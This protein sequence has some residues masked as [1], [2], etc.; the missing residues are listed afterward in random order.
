MEADGV[1][2]LSEKIG[3]LQSCARNASI[4]VRGYFDQ[5]LSQDI[6]LKAIRAWASFDPKKGSLK[7]WVFTIASRLTIDAR[8]RTSKRVRVE[9]DEPDQTSTHKASQRSYGA[10]NGAVDVHQVLC[11]SVG[12]FTL[13]QVKVL[14][15]G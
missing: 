15:Y 6:L 9:S 5:D 1:A 14:A 10:F 7:N 2:D 12:K 4:H 11:F 8:R 13:P 3:E